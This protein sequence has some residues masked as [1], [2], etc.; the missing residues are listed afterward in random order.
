MK[1]YM[2]TIDGGT[3]NTRAYLWDVDGTLLGQ[4]KSEVGVRDTAADGNCDR[5]SRAVKK[6]IE[7]LLAEASVDAGELEAVY[8]SGMIS[9]NVGLYELPHLTAPATLADFAA[10]TREVFLPEICPAPIR[11]IPGLKNP[12][13]ESGLL[14]RVEEMDMMR[15]EETEALALLEKI[16]E[17]QG[18]VLVLPGSHTK[19]VFVSEKQELT[20]CLTSLTGELL[21]VLTAQSIVADAVKKAFVTGLPDEEYLRAGYRAAE[22]GGFAR[23]AF[24]TRTTAQFI[25]G[26]QH[27]C[28]SF[29]LGA[30]LQNDL[31]AIRSRRAQLSPETTIV[32]AGKEPLASSMTLLLREEGYFSD[33]RQI[34]QTELGVMSGTGARLVHLARMRGN[35]S[36]G[37]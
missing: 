5:L 21:A 34:P 37:R 25:N 24:L 14:S 29:L 10:G 22:T 35:G 31:A 27:A 11:F 18:M 33:I 15:G 8:A 28:A 26:S 1:R 13:N 6:L 30:V 2:I 12:A 17:H 32:V 19:F 36:L 3:T 4:Q 20:G 23:A 9:S 16:P 7:N